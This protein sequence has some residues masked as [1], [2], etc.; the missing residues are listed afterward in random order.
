MSE[1]E[2]LSAKTFSARARE[3]LFLCIKVRQVVLLLETASNPNQLNKSEIVSIRSK[4]KPNQ[5]NLKPKPPHS[6]RG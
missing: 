1:N 4:N 6:P 5:T 2:V 3:T